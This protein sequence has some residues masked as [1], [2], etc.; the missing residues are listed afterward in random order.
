MSLQISYHIQTVDSPFWS[1]AIHDGHHIDDDLL[2]YLLLNSKQRLREEDP[3]TALI[4]E[5]PINQFVVG[6]SRFQLDLNRDIEQSV[7]LRPELAWGLDVWEENLPSTFLEILYKKHRDVYRIIE[8]HIQ[9]TIQK[10]GFF[11]VLDVHSYN[12]KRTSAREEVDKEANPQINLGTYYNTPKWRL[13]T[14][15]FVAAIQGQKLYGEPIDIREN[16]KF[17]GGYLSQFINANFGEKGCVLAIEFRKDFMNE[18]T[19]EPDV[20]RIA[21]C[22][23]LLINTVQT[24]KDYFVYER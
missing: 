10:Y 18:W 15:N 22:K 24:L 17:K 12:A 9:T 1:F 4:A 19:G 20:Q 23:Q 16:V 8:R 3:Y 2:P 14:D 5:L 11:V 7:Y 6:T 13:L 21:A